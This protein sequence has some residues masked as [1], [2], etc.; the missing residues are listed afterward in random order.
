LNFFDGRPLFGASKTVRGIALSLNCTALAAVPLGFDWVVGAELAALSL[1]GDLL[2]SFVKRRLGRPL[3]SAAYGL[4]QIPESLL[5]L[6]VLRGTL[7]ITFVDIALIVVLFFV[8]E[9]ILSRLLFKLH[10]RDRPS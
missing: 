4:D 8:L 2:S 5:P 6:L 3:H 10:I 1:L 7:G 9:L